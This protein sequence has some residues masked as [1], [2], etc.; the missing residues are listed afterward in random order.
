ME[1]FIDGGIFEII[2]V[3]ALAFVINYI[4]IKKMLLI[5]Y[6]VITILL[7]VSLLLLSKGALFDIVA[8]IVFLNSVLLV[9]ILWREKKRLQGAKLFESRKLKK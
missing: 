3:L 2:A 8:A 5:V 7:P 9:I 1:P 4:F 6:S